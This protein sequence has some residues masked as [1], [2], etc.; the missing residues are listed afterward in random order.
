VHSGKELNKV[1]NS[2]KKL[3]KINTISKKYLSIQ[4]NSEIC[5]FYQ[6]FIKSSYTIIDKI[7]KISKN[8]M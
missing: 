3:D 1:S 5:K 7:L 8:P 6:G 2:R 4:V